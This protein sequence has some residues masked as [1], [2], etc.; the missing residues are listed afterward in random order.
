MRRL[1]V[2]LCLLWAP[3]LLLAQEWGSI[4]GSTVTMKQIPPAWPGCE[5][6]ERANWDQCFNNQLSRH[7]AAQFRY[8]PVAYQNNEEG[9]VEV[10]FI[11]NKRGLVKIQR[12]KGGTPL[13]QKEAR[14]IIEAIPP[15]KVPSKI[16]GKATT[17]DYTVPITF[18]TGK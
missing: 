10:S 9:R 2:L 7:I 13:L 6:Q 12:V 16:G 8:P 4:S 11:I 15:M 14:R 1:A 18:S 17:I 3:T 5:T